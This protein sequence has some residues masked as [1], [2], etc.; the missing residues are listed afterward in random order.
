M[1]RVKKRM[2]ELSATIFICLFILAN[3][4]AGS[5]DTGFVISTLGLPKTVSELSARSSLIVTG[6]VVAISPAREVP[7]ERKP[8]KLMPE[9]TPPPSRGPDFLETDVIVRIDRVLKGQVAAP[10]IVI[11]QLGGV[12]PGRSQLP[13]QFSLMKPGEQFI[14][15]LVALDP[16]E[17]S[18]LPEHPG[19]PRYSIL[20]AFAGM[21][22]VEAGR[23]TISPGMPPS[24]RERY[25]GKMASEMLQEIELQ[26][27]SIVP[28]SPWQK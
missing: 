4:A 26:E 7:V 3:R 11:Y 12:L 25:D 20:D 27:G 28:S 5:Q 10:Q 18:R 6:T 23:L 8:S 21:V 2:K 1:L 9:F 16:T 13:T 14:L 15:Y 19:G 24:F 22:H 17:R